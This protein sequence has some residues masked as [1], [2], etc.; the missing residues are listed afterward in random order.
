MHTG[1]LL[2]HTGSFVEVHGPSSC[3]E[4]PQQLWHEAS[5]CGILLL[6][7]LPDQGS[8]PHPWRG[9]ADSPLDL[10]QGS[11]QYTFR[12]YFLSFGESGVLDQPTEKLLVTEA[13][14]QTSHLLSQIAPSLSGSFGRHTLNLVPVSSDFTPYGF[15]FG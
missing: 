15:S 4:Q 14:C 9:K 3:G 5:A 2:C 7:R 13:S 12:I 11:P 8:N 6:Q 10:P 1:S